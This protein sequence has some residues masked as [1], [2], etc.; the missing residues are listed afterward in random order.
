MDRLEILREISLERNAQ[1]VKWG[2]NADDTLNTPN[3]FVAYISHHATRWFGGG[4]IPYSEETVN[5]F[6]R[7]MVKVA[8]LAVAAI[9]SVDRQRAKSVDGITFY[10]AI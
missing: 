7:Q 8:A 6:R 1:E 5:K 3:D 10:E 4:F 9:E 2:N